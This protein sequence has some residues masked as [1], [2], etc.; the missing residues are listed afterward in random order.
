M[1]KQKKQ[2]TQKKHFNDLLLPIVATLCLLPFAVYYAEYDYGYSKYLWHSDNSVI[3]DFYTYNRAIFFVVIIVFALIILAFRF[4]L[5]REDFKKSKIFLP[6]VVYGVFAL[7]SAIFSVDKTASWMGKT[8]DCESIIILLAYPLIGYYTYQIMKKEDDYQS[9]FRSM[10]V[11]F[12]PMSIVGWFQVC[13]QDLLNY[14]W[15]QKIVMSD[16]DYEVYGGMVEDIFTG[17]NVFLTLYNPN[18]AAIFLVMFAA[19]FAV[20]FLCATEKKQKILAAVYLIDALVLTW[21]TYTRAALVAFVVVAVCM[22]LCMK[23]RKFGKSGKYLVAGFTLML[24]VLVAGDVATGGKYV[25][26]IFDEP[27]S[28]R[29][30]SMLTT[31][32]G[33][34]IV[35]DDVKY[36]VAFEEENGEVTGVCLY[37]ADGKALSMDK[38]AEGDFILPFSE[39]A[40]VTLLEWE[41]EPQILMQIEEVALQFVCENGTY[42]YYTEWGKV[43]SMTEIASVDFG[44]Y[45]Y[46][47]SGRVYI[48]SRILPMLKDYIVVGSGPSTFAE[49]F[50]QNDYAGK[51]V[52][53]DNPGRIIERAHNDYLMRWVQTGLCSLIALLVFYF[54]FLKKCWKYYRICEMTT[55]QSRLGFACFLGCVA[56][57]VC[58]LFSDSTLYTTPVFYVFL[59]IALAATDENASLG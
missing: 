41:G 8:L 17:N 49:V 4:A 16:A 42:Y 29:L 50:P 21:F 35:Y 58:G 5:Y 32:A 13:K 28:N 31:E 55:T 36:T 47:G 18:Y 33:V 39:D 34:E 46:I 53:A 19:V 26:R 23:K 56:Y 54:L 22:V 11:M 30:S 6:L 40:R 20:W 51:L 52:Y 12:V 38:T 27:K 3:Q 43:D 1:K 57:M 59:G 25:S 44:G 14:D 48:W 37:G 24:V 2:K 7:L 10:Q 9:I 15:V 45:E